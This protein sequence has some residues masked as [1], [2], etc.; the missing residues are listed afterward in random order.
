MQMTVTKEGIEKANKMW[1]DLLASMKVGKRNIELYKQTFDKM[2]LEDFNILVDRIEKGNFLFPVI[3][4]NM[5]ENVKTGFDHVIEICKKHNIPIFERLYLTDPVTGMEFLTPEKALVLLMPSRRQI[6]HLS[7]KISL[8]ENDKVVDSLSGQVTGP[9]KGASIT[10][11]EFN[12]LLGK[13]YEAAIAELIK[14]RGGDEEAFKAMVEQ[15]EGT[16]GMAIQPILDMGTETAS[17]R[18]LRALL[19]G[20]HLDNDA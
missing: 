15:L 1:L 10:F 18:T 17:V 8:P 13:G 4:E 14:L 5:E 11:P 20:M 6:H 19:L 2:S 9:S 16:G 7:K 3:V 12:A